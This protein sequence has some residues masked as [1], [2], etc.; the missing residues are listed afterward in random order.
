MGYTSL[1]DFLVGFWEGFF[2]ARDPNNLLTMLST[3]T[4]GNVG[5]TPGFDGSV[6]KALASIKV[7]QT[8]PYKIQIFGLLDTSCSCADQSR[9]MRM[10]W[11]MSKTWGDEMRD[12]PYLSLLRIHY[13]I[14]ILRCR[15]R[16][17]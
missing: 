5:N 11:S 2:L 17:L 10:H 13:L 6:E 15:P 1:E 12:H 7:R 8:S 4:N 16:Q 3:W 14:V 9:T